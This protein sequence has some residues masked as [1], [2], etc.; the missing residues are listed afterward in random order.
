MENKKIEKER[1]FSIELQ[2]KAD[3]KNVT[4]TN[5]LNEN[6]MFEG[7]IGALEEAQ[8]VE[9]KILRIVGS[10]G[11][12]LVDISGNEIRKTTPKEVKQQ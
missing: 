11:V 6:S 9:E 7:T 2:S 10:K 3:L 12:I 4:L 8:F 1:S 5:N